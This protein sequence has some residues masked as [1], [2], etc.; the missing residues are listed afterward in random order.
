MQGTERA[1]TN[2]VH[3]WVMP[4]PVDLKELTYAIDWARRRAEEIHGPGAGSYDNAGMLVI[5]DEEHVAMR[6]PGTSTTEPTDR[7]D[8]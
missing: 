5:L 6:V 8:R 7:S 2:T 4:T 1:V 3:E